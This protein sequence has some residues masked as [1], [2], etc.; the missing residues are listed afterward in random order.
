MEKKSPFQSKTNYVALALAI[1]AF[2]PAVQKLI[3]ENPEAFALAVAGVFGFM[4][5]ISHGKI[6]I[7]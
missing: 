4:R 5:Q 3:S 6:S 1:A 2:F 7:E